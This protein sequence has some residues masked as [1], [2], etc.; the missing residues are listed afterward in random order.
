M[1]T[2][3]TY[4]GQIIINTSE[5]ILKDPLL[6]LVEKVRKRVEA[7]FNKEESLKGYLKAAA[8]DASQLE[9]EIQEEWNLIV[10]DIYAMYPLLIKYVDLHKNEWI[11]QNNADAEELFNVINNSAFFKKEETTFVSTN[12]IDTMALIMP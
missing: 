9:G 2:I 3:A 12:E 1:T 6:P 5:E 7:M 11:K 8:D 4:S 10:R